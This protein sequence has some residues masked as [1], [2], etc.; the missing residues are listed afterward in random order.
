[1]INVRV[2][3]YQRIYIPMNISWSIEFSS[4][5]NVTNQ[6]KLHPNEPA[7]I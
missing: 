1:M 7:I 3:S 2:L 5:L 4:I 6:F